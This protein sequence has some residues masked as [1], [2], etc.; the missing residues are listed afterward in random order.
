M[1][2]LNTL[3]NIQCPRCEAVNAT[4]RFFCGQCGERLWNPCPACRQQ[5]LFD[6]KFCGHCG[7]D[8]RI[9]KDALRKYFETAWE[10]AL[11]LRD[12]YRFDEALES[13][14]ML[15]KT[16][17]FGSEELVTATQDLIYNCIV[18]RKRRQ[19]ELQEKGELIRQCLSRNEFQEAGGLLAE[20]P[21]PLFTEDLRQLGDLVQQGLTEGDR[22]RQALQA[23]LDAPLSIDL[24][25]NL[26]RFLD[27]YPEDPFALEMAVRLQRDLE[28]H[29]D[30]FIAECQY[31]K[32]VKILDRVPAV[33]FNESLKL[34]H[35]RAQE[36]LWLTWDLRRSPVAD[37][38]LQ[39]LARR[40]RTLAP[41]D[42][43]IAEICRTLELRLA[44]NTQDKLPGFIPWAA[45]PKRTILGPP[46]EWIGNL[47]RIS[48]D[49]KTDTA[50]YQVYPGRFAAA[51][52]LALQGLDQGPIRCNFLPEEGSLL[53][54]LTSWKSSRKPVAAWGVDIGSHSLKA[55]KLRLEG[56]PP[57]IHLE[58]CD[59]IEHRKL[60]SQTANEN[61]YKT[62]VEE[63][64]RN[65]LSKHKLEN[66][67]VCLGL[68]AMHFFFGQFDLPAR[69][70]AKVAAAVEFEAQ[71]LFPQPLKEL[72]W[73]Y[74]DLSSPDLSH[75]EISLRRITVMGVKNVLLKYRLDTIARAGL[76]PDIVQSDAVALYNFAAFNFFPPATKT[77]APRTEST[78][79]LALVDFGGDTMNFVVCGPQTFWMRS[80]SIGSDRLNRMLVKQF[81]LTFSQ[82]EQWKRDPTAAPEIGKLWDALRDGFADISHSIVEAGDTYQIAFPHAPLQRFLT[83]GGG[84]LVHGL[85][86]YLWFE[87]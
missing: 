51:C 26:G 85:L 84:F 58:V 3:E 73:N 14:H 76:K 39:T 66:E 67:C 61:E 38:V 33:L 56:K 12:E 36:L 49:P 45:P 20:I 79:H 11:R 75:P 70:A 55:V 5:N 22:L 57:S 65:F 60:L 50:T 2:S 13:Y 71:Y 28:Q 43:K 6:Q 32:A 83:V 52:G 47:E 77:D 69:D 78:S 53:K 17:K 30:K 62:I 86:R 21:P 9:N 46:V 64:I 54:R 27:L 24:L 44:K 42:C 74:V 10:E 29:A 18:E 41:H 80:F 15:V 82:S 81:K 23:T 59:C 37:P 7:A 31:D 19:S 87:R 35:N 72:V 1:N 34:L 63:T 8:L 40:F 48:L 4:E 16:A 68:S 25:K